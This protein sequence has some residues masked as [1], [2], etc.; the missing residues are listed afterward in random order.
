MP[1]EGTR[2]LSVFLDFC[3]VSVRAMVVTG[4]LSRS[5]WVWHRLRFSS[6]GG[7]D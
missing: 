5:S 2:L 6:P 4:F 1:G 7:A 3:A